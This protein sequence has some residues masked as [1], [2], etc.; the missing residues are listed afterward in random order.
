MVLPYIDLF[1][2][3]EVSYLY[4]EIM[5]QQTS[6]CKLLQVLFLHYS[7]VLI[8]MGI[9]LRGIGESNFCCELIFH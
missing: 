6:T 7:E 3:S 4:L 9:K 2:L 8:Y 1:K 5:N